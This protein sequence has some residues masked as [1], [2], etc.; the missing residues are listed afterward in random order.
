M[1]WVQTG[2]GCTNGKG[3]PCIKC[4][5][6]ASGQARSMNTSTNYSIS[7][8]KKTMIFVKS[9]RRVLKQPMDSR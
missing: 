2:R 8:L 9:E 3:L 6:F 1:G 7:V 4:C 5:W